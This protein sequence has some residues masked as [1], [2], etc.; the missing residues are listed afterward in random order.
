MN[1]KKVSV[2]ALSG[3]LLTSAVLPSISHAQTPSKT[4]SSELKTSNELTQFTELDKVLKEE[5]ISQ[6]ELIDYGRYVN[7]ESSKNGMQEIKISAAKKAIKF[8]VK[9]ADTIPSKTVRDAVKKYGGKIVSALDTIETYS[10]WGIANGLN[11]V[12][13]PDRYATLIADF[14]VTFIL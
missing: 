12:G 6:Q 3:A 8:M 11:K 14:I 5:N 10:W 13:V 1:F 4:E 2:L 9:N 7:E